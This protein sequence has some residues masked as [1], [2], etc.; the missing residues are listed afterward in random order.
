MRVQRH[1]NKCHANECHA[2]ERHANVCHANIALQ[3]DYIRPVPV[4]YI[5]STLH[6]SRLRNVIMMYRTSCI[7]YFC[8]KRWCDV[9][10]CLE[11]KI[12]V[13][14]FLLHTASH[15]DVVQRLCRW[16]PMLRRKGC[17]TS[18]RRCNVSCK[19]FCST[20]YVRPFCCAPR[21]ISSWPTTSCQPA[22]SS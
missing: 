3:K 12:M 8:Y 6:T 20:G 19:I 17:K 21:S 22:L 10:L 15:T 16:G 5:T 1:A 13:F 2:N 11:R 4:K 9:T 14:L 18:V 7:S